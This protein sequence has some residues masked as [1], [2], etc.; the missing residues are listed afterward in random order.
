MPFPR[1]FGA[2]KQL[3]GVKELF[4]KEAP[5]QVKRSRK[6]LY[7]GIDHDYYGFRDEEDGVLL[8]VE[9]AA[10]KKM[11]AKV[12]GGLRWK[13]PLFGAFWTQCG[14]S[15]S[16]SGGELLGR[17]RG[18]FVERIWEAVIWVPS[19]LL[20]FLWALGGAIGHWEDGGCKWLSE[21]VQVKGI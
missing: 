16:G 7:S 11:R 13:G 10:E 14:A 9:A 1:Y 12:S 15:R 21:F 20:A 8:K 19:S 6:D 18:Q 3:P 2:A 17:H 5:K 4:E